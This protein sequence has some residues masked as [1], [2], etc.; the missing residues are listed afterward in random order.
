MI[1]GIGKGCLGTGAALG[2]GGVFPGWAAVFGEV[3]IGAVFG[4]GGVLPGT[5]TVLCAGLA[6]IVALPE[7]EV[8]GT[9]A[10]LA[11]VPET[12]GFS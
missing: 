1:C 11:P 9:A 5:G 10:G 3:V 12:A 7:G 2:S 4:S 8:G 6:G